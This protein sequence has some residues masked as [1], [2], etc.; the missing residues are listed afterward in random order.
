MDLD[1]ALQSFR[2]TSSHE[3]AHALR[4]TAREYCEDG[5]I[6]DATYNAYVAETATFS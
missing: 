5:M 3:T 4:E 1:T 6:Q 2:T